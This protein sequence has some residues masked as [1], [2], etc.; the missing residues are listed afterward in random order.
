MDVLGHIKDM[1]Y[2]GWCDGCTRNADECQ[3]EYYET[4]QPPLCCKSCKEKC[5]EEG[6]EGTV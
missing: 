5:E 2:N 3:K 4:R 6:D 1:M